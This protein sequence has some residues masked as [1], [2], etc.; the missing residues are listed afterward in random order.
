MSATV[1]GELQSSLRESAH[2][3]RMATG[4]EDYDGYGLDGIQRMQASPRDVAIDQAG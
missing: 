2:H 4:R 1:E 3:L